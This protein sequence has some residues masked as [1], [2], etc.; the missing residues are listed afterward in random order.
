MVG[1][2]ELVAYTDRLLSVDSFNDYCPNGLQVQGQPE[3]RTLIGGV[4][5][6]SL[7]HI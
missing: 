3:V 7:I 1:L 5:A 6:L 4:T 2:G